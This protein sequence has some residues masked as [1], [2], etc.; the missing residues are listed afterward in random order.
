MNHHDHAAR[1]DT[2][3]GTVEPLPARNVHGFPIPAPSRWISSE[4]LDTEPNPDVAHDVILGAWVEVD[5]EAIAPQRPPALRLPLVVGL[6]VA[7]IA[8][9]ASV[10][11]W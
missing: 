2:R 3:A 1:I 9:A 8:F 11:P 10:A 5:L 7:L 4:F 6:V